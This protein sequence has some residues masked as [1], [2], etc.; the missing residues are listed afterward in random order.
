MAAVALSLA[1]LPASPL[2]PAGGGGGASAA[3]PGL[4]GEEEEEEAEAEAAAAACSRAMAMALAFSSL[5]PPRR[6][7]ACLDGAWA[8]FRARAC[9]R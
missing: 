6:A 5:N 1:A 9:A 2:L 8:G 7:I 3:A 4:A